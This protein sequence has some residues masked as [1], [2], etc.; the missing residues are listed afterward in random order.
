M[1]K[2]GIDVSRHQAE[3][4][5][6]KVADAG[7]LWAAMR[8][9]IG[10]YYFDD[11]FEFN[12][13]GAKAVGIIPFPYHV[14]RTDKGDEAQTNWFLEHLG[15]RKTWMNVIDC[16]V[17]SGSSKTQRG[18]V[19]NYTMRDIEAETHAMTI[20]YTNAN[21]W[22]TYMPPSFGGRQFKN[23]VLH[24]ASYGVNDGKRP[25]KPPYPRLPD[26]WD[27]YGAWQ[28]TD[29]GRVAGINANVDL[30]DMRN[31][32]Y[33]NLRA[34]SGIPEPGGAQPPPT[35]PDVP[36]PPTDPDPIP[37]MRVFKGSFE[38]LVAEEGDEVG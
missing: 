22:N 35:D 23:S 8:C 11:K 32:T 7:I 3:I 9:T 26:L 17:V 37:G 12:F 29:R 2:P 30:D 15:G 38:V 4:D 20:I 13:D 14:L 19:L 34:R 28:Y 18:S 5:W 6:Q 27:D 16:E 25:P 1:S 31:D 36:L 21:F 10:D 24:V 33:A